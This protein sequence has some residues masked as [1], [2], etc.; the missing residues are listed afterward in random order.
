MIHNRICTNDKSDQTIKLK[1]KLVLVNNALLQGWATLFGS[2][3]AQETKI[4]Y[5]GQYKY[6][7]ELFDLNFMT[8]L[9]FSSLF[10]GKKPFERYFK[11]FINLKKC[12]RATLRCLAGRMWSAG[13]TLPRPALLSTYLFLLINNFNPTKLYFL[14]KYFF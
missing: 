3:A 7:M 4:I 10:I 13:P 9:N 8:K 2:R 14:K 5:V 1:K 6:H 12:S 11:W